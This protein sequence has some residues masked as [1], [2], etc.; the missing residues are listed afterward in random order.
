MCC[1]WKKSCQRL[2]DRRWQLFLLGF[3]WSRGFHPGAP[4]YFFRS[5]RSSSMTLT[6]AATKSW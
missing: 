6:Q 2:I 4:C 1:A 5:K 3:S